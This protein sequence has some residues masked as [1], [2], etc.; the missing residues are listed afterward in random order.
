MFEPASDVV[1]RVWDGVAAVRYLAR[2]DVRFGD[3][4]DSGLFW[5]TDIYE[6]HA[7]G[8][9]VV[10]SQATPTDERDQTLAP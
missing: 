9:R 8:W 7:N 2:I 3:G 5:H 1:V 10:W 4:R 6:R